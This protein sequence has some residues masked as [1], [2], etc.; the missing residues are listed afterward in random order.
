MT[1]ST[2]KSAANALIELFTNHPL[3]AVFQ[4]RTPEDDDKNLEKDWQRVSELLSGA[5]EKYVRQSTGKRVK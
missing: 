5:T 2:L 1:N 3:M 4:K